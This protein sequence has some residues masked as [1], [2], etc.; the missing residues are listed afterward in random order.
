MRLRALEVENRE[1]RDQLDRIE[2]N[3]EAQSQARVKL[4]SGGMRLLLP[5]LDREHVIRS[6]GTL[7]ETVARFGE[8]RTAWPSREE[9]L[10]HARE[11]MSSVVRF[12]LRRRM[13]WLFVSLIAAAIPAAQVWIA[14]KQNEIIEN[15]NKFFEVQVYDVVA[16]SMTEGDRN[17]RLMTGALLA[18]ADPQFLEGVI[19]EAFNP[20][21]A[22]LYRAEGV[23]ATE[24]RLS[25]TAFRGN[26]VRAAVRS[27][28]LHADAA[29][30]ETSSTAMLE[31]ILRDAASRVPETLR[32]G[33][34]DAEL[35]PE[36]AEQVDHYLSQVG[37]ALR[38][39]S[40][41][42]RSNGSRRRFASGVVP[43]F[44]R[45]STRRVNVGGR[46]DSVLRA[47]M[48]DFLFGE[49]VQDRLGDPPPELAARGLTP[50]AALKRGLDSLKSELDGAPD[51]DSIR[52]KSIMGQVKIQ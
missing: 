40:R 52:W 2:H 19:T 4:V 51:G 24:R 5:L 23:Q 43:F 8:S 10:L 18:N 48:Q 14:F 25:D 39:L 49:A 50:E 34:R 15:Q 35:D 13:F 29:E 45:L 41:L 17:A 32:L 42:S 6:F 27:V 33:A 22:N 36:L 16:R 47:S 38:M 28:E 11:F 37:S 1:L 3:A 26:L 30:S 44:S 9:V 21:L 46:F 31:L 7:T 12:G 20:S